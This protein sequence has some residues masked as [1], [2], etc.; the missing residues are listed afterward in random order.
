MKKYILLSLFLVSCIFGYAQTDRVKKLVKDGVTLHD[1]GKYSDALTK[2][3]EAISLDDTYFDAFYE[4]AY[5]L[6]AMKRLEECCDLS[7]KIVRQ[8]PDEPLLKGVYVHYG[9]AMDE[10]GK[11]KAAIKIYDE[12]LKKFPGYFLLN[13]N[14]GITYAI[15]NE[16]DKAYASYKEALIDNPFHTSSY[17]R[18][19]EM[20]RSTNRIPA[21]LACIMH[22]MLEPTS[23]RSPVSFSMLKELIYGNVK[24]T[25]DNTITITMDPDMLDSKKSKN[26][27]DNFSMQEMLFTMS[28][29]LDKDSV[30]SSITKTDIEK[31]DLKFQLLINS[32]PGEGKGFFTERYVPF[33]KS[34]KENDHTMIVSR[35]VFKN[36]N[37]EAN[38]AWLKVNTDKV[39]SFYEWVKAYPWP[40]K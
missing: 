13:F 18:V 27:E 16:Q 22:L 33:F 34:L 21:M 3:D 5:T 20:L 28:S 23:D 25:G 19:A 31:F 39:A 11:S 24:K 35:L 15:M 9:S 7:K 36:T 6:Y 29:A 40:D 10:L 30:L 2:Y 37:D 32:L 4:K 26:K 14:K 12:G 1:Q 8:F 38:A 17:F